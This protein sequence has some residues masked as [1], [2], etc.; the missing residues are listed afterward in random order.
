MGLDYLY[1][2]WVWK[3]YLKLCGCPSYYTFYIMLRYGYRTT[4]LLKCPQ[5]LGISFWRGGKNKYL[6]PNTTISCWWQQ[7]GNPWPKIVLFF[8]FKNFNLSLSWG[9][10]TSTTLICHCHGIWPY[11]CK[12]NYRRVF[13]TPLL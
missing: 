3:T 4:G 5:C 7:S 10:P 12:T 13:K 9:D 8:F 2:W 6:T 1:L 11:I